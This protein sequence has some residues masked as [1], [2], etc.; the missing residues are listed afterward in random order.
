MM[1]AAPAALPPPAGTTWACSSNQASTVIYLGNN[2][3][4]GARHA[5]HTSASGGVY[6]N[7]NYHTM[8]DS[9]KVFLTNPSDNSPADLV[10][11]IRPCPCH[12]LGPE[13]TYCWWLRWCSW[14][15]CQVQ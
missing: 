11:A 1:L 2:W 12:L 13:A 15:M 6:I 9:S 8:I 4:L 7:G 5:T 14:A 10:L 3:V